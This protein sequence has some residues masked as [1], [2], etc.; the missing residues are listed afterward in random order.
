MNQLFKLKNNHLTPLD[1]VDEKLQTCDYK[2]KKYARLVLGIGVN[3]EY[4]YLLNDWF[5]Q[6]QYG[7]VF[8]YIES[9]NCKYFI[10]FIPLSE[11]GY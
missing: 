11:L 3:V 9:V 10:D 1:S 2:K 8:D 5:D 7:D 4:Y 6:P